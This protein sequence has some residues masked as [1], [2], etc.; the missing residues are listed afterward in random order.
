MNSTLYRYTHT[1][2]TMVIMGFLYFGVATP[3]FGAG[4]YVPLVGIPGISGTPS[5][6]DYINKIYIL[7]IAIGVLIAIMRIAFAGVKYS[8]SGV[9]TDK[10]D[11]K[12]DI[13]GVLLG[14][15]ILL[16]PAL[17]LNTIN[18]DLLRLNFLDTAPKI[19]MATGGVV[20]DNGAGLTEMKVT[21]RADGTTSTC[22]D[23]CTALKGVLSKPTSDPYDTICTYKM[24]MEV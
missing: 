6:P 9:I 3:V 5:L 15:A 20:Q 24:G 22:A 2:I 10:S 1:R 12:K 16:L 13:K 11:A 14:L 8:M 17:V 19:N 23:Q 18:P 21:C 4:T 7:I